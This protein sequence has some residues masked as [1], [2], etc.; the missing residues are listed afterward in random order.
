MS[1]M[2]GLLVTRLKPSMP[3][4][5]STYSTPAAS[6]AAASL[7]LD[8]TGCVGDVG[9]PG[10]E[11]LEAVAGTGP[12]TETPHAGVGRAEPSATSELIGSTV[13]EP[14]TTHVTTDVLGDVARRPP[15]GGPR[16]LGLGPR[17]VGQGHVAGIAD[18][19]A[20]LVTEVAVDV[21]GHGLVVGRPVEVDVE[22]EVPGERIGAGGD[23]LVGGDDTGAVLSGNG[24]GPTVSSFSVAKA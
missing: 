6:Q 4:F 11:E 17:L 20:P 10:A 22:V 13:E 9:V 18:G 7:V 16:R 23:G 14:E 2:V 1:A 15:A 12:S 8:G 24:E 21:G 5:S 19:L 3:I